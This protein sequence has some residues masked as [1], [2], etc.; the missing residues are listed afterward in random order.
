MGVTSEVDTN[1]GV[2]LLGSVALGVEGANVG[3]LVIVAM[4]GVLVVAVAV[5]ES[6]GVMAAAHVA[7]GVF[8]GRGLLV[9]VAGRLGVKE[10]SAVGCVAMGVDR[11]TALASFVD[12]KPVPIKI[13]M[14]PANSRSVIPLTMMP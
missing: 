10:G 2:S 1:V 7:L 5:I 12:G 4:V 13:I 14:A 11:R 6:S 9:V 8:E 3:E